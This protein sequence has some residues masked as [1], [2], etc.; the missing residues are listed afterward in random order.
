MKEGLKVFPLPAL[1]DNYI[2]V[3]RDE[4]QDITAVVDPAEP[5]PVIDFLNNQGWS[6]N[7]VLNTH[8]HHDHIGGNAELKR[9]YDC[10]IVA[11]KY[12]SHRISPIDLAVEDGAQINVGSHSAKVFYIPG[13]TSG[14][15]A[16]WFFNDEQ[17]FCG[18]TMFVM[19]CGRLF[20]GS[21][22]QMWQSLRRLASLPLQTKI[23]CAHEYTEK[24]GEFALQVEPG[25]NNLKAKMKKVKETRAKG[26]ATIPTSVREEL[27]TNPFLRPNST[28]I[29]SRLHMTDA[30]DVEVFAR[31]REMKDQF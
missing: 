27:E 12:D 18:D 29:R 26:L 14:H 8:H 28:E 7:K 1:N 6:L 30:A 21:P 5:Q 3:L 20:E 9:V 16:Y 31:L 19:G 13:H 17:V 11:P 22:E 2:F 15:V 25:N 10:E 23:Y 4:D 24:N